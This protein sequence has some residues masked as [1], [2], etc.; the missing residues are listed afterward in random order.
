MLLKPDLGILSLRTKA[1]SVKI[2]WPSLQ[3]T[4][5]TWPSWSTWSTS[6]CD[7]ALTWPAPW[8]SFQA[9]ICD[10]LQKMCLISNAHNSALQRPI[11]IIST[12]VARLFPQLQTPS[13][14]MSLN[15]LKRPKTGR[16]N[17]MVLC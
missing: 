9:Q 12:P 14:Q 13:S 10:F 2:S 4:C 8:A 3:T 17:C 1:A 6:P 11:C 15:T 16:R 7:P 5:A